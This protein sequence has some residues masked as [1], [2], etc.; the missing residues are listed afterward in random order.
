MFMEVIQVS[1]QNTH[2]LKFLRNMPLILLDVAPYLPLFNSVL[3][4]FLPHIFQFQPLG[5][6]AIVCLF[7]LSSF[8][9][10]RKWRLLLFMLGR[11]EV[12]RSCELFPFPVICLCNLM[13]V[14]PIGSHYVF[15]CCD[16]DSNFRTLMC[17]INDV[18]L[19]GNCLSL[20]FFHVVPD[21]SSHMPAD[22]IDG[23][24]RGNCGMNS[25]SLWDCLRSVSVGGK[26]FYSFQI[27]ALSNLKSGM[28]RTDPV[29][30]ENVG[31]LKINLS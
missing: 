28:E 5:H 26:C 29:L 3:S 24:V 7:C 19:L 11:A 9:A 12:R 22:L 18:Q 14:V 2:F 10:E 1:F 20:A 4:F 16:G 8:I 31:M 27:H 6:Y 23:D 13:G 30:T 15:D 25:L 21:F 17:W